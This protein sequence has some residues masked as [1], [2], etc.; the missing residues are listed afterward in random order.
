MLRGPEEAQR[1]QLAMQYAPEPPFH[2]GTP[3]TAP[4][5]ALADVLADVRADLAATMRQREHTARRIST[6]LGLLMDSHAVPEPTPS[7][8]AQVQPAGPR[9]VDPGAAGTRNTARHV[10]AAAS[11][12]VTTFVETP[13]R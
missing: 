8:N 6:R 1:I 9:A 13:K 7:A 10:R 2:A 12:G 11:G 5:D 4:A 3:D